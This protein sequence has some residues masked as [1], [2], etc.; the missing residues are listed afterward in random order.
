MDE[1]ESRGARSRRGF[2]AGAAGAAADPAIEA[3]IDA[4][5]AALDDADR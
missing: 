4:A 2:L 3:R 5:L 1:T